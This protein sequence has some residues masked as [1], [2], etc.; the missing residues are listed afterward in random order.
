MN[1][2]VD[3]SESASHRSILSTTSMMLAR[4]LLCPAD[5]R[6]ESEFGCLFRN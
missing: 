1:R 2:M 3:P 6:T 4:Q 5:P